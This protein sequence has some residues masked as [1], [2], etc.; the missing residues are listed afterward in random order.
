MRNTS[1]KS[2]ARTRRRSATLWL[3]RWRKSVPRRSLIKS[4][5]KSDELKKTVLVTQTKLNV[6]SDRFN[7]MHAPLI[8]IQPL[9]VEETFLEHEYDWLILTS[10]NAV[11]LFLPYME[12]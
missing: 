2:P 5:R 11:K 8:S 1:S 3:M 7:V 9:E 6:T 10:K 4:M 12:D